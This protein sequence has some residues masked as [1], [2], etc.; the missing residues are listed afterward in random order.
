M[1]LALQRHVGRCAV[2]PRTHRAGSGNHAPFRGGRAAGAGTRRAW[3][4]A[5]CAV[6]LVVIA[7]GRPAGAAAPATTPP[8]AGGE[9]VKVFVSILPEA[10]FVERVGGPHV[11]VDVLVGPGQSPHIFEPT[12]KQIVRLSQ[13]QVFFSIGWP[14]EA[15]LLS[16]ITATAPNLKVVPLQAGLKLRQFTDD[17]QKAD[18]AAEARAA[19]KAAPEAAQPGAPGEPDPH[20]WLS[21]RNARLMAATVAETLIALDPA[22][23]DVFRKNL[24]AL[25][26]DLARLDA[27][28]AAALAP[29]KGK[30]FFVYHPAFGYFADA[31][32]LRQVPVEIEGKEP[33]ARQLTALVARAKKDGVRVIFV[34]PQFSS[35]SAEV[36]AQAIGG[37]VVPMDDLAR[38]YLA[39]LKDMAEKVRKAL[40]AP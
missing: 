9:P 17:E 40:A 30:E 10:Y 18:E 36:V 21:P 19:G 29:L 31:Y 3:F 27:D 35:R 26:A 24:A 15:R 2:G 28:I 6:I 38:D 8:A 39:N 11:L 14:F 23:A 5:G 25:D 32:G 4:L 34:E 37:A 12:P 16:K 13:A 22:H 20:V 33:A 7:A 1:L